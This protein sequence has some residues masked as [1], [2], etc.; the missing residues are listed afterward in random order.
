[1]RSVYFLFYIIIL[2]SSPHV[3]GRRNHSFD[4]TFKSRLPP[5]T[6]TTTTSSTSAV[7]LRGGGAS[8]LPNASTYWSRTRTA[9]SPSSPTSFSNRQSHQQHKQSDNIKVTDV[10]QEIKTQE[11]QQ[12][13][14]SIDE[15]LTRDNRNTFIARVYSILAVQLLFTIASVFAFAKHP[16]LV[17]WVLAKGKILPN[18][19]ILLSTLAFFRMAMSETARRSSPMKWILLATFTFGKAFMVGLISSFYKSKTVIS[20]LTSTFLALISV[21]GYTLLNRNPKYDLSQW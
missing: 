8:D 5:I 21:T 2:I 18:A 10:T 12:T 17:H 16:K 11:Q 14:E 15:I 4:V 1:M 9:T 19:S 20:A 6:T 13:K 3:K 7:L